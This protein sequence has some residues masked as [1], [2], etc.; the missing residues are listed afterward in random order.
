MMQN[1]LF[2]PYYEA[3]LR[4]Q[5]WDFRAKDYNEVTSDKLEPEQEKQNLISFFL[6]EGIIHPDSRVLDLGC[7]PGKFT[8]VFA[9]HVKEIIGIDISEN[10]VEY[11]KKNN[12]SYKNAYFMIMDWGKDSI[13]ELGTFDLV[14]ANMC[15]AIY[16]IHTLSKMNSVSHGYCYYSHFSARSNNIGD[17]LD[18]LFKIKHTFSRIPNMFSYLWEKGYRPTVH[19]E[20]KGSESKL[21]LQDAF[22]YYQKEYNYGNEKKEQVKSIL[23]NYISH[24]GM[25]HRKIWFQKGILLWNVNTPIRLG[26]KIV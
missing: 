22:I 15:P 14:F 3:M 26:G 17:D 7:G 9:P 2:D 21:S 20:E 23:Q 10:M 8:Q 11:A 5:Y 4:K 6:K 19:Y 24:D 25:I 12:S 13:S 1:R 18:L 16:D